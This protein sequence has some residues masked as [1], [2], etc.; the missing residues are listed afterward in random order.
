MLNEIYG[1][2]TI[3]EDVNITFPPQHQNR[4]PGWEYV[5]NPIPES[6]PRKETGKLIGKVALITGGDSGIGRAIAYLFVRRADIAFVYFHEREDAATNKQGVEAY[7][8]NA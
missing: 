3:C 1:K 4:M 2:K 8:G 7:H 6:P 5:M